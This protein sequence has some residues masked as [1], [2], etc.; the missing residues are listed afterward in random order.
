MGSQYPAGPPRTGRAVSRDVLKYRHASAGALILAI[1]MVFASACDTPSEQASPTTAPTSALPAPLFPN[2]PAV[3]NDFRFHWSAAPG[4][5]LNSGPAV[6]LR[7]YLES[8]RLAAFAGGDPSVVYPGFMRST[9]ENQ[10]PVANAGELFQLEYIRPQTRAEYEANGW[11]YVERQVYGYQPTHVLS[12]IPQGDGYRATVCVGAYSVYRTADDDPQKFFSTAA[13]EQTGQ[14]T[15]G[16]RDEIQVW[17][18]ELT[19]NDPRVANAPAPPT[20]QQLGPMPAPVDDVFG[21]WFI[22]GAG[23]ALWGPSGQ[24]EHIDTPE[25]RQQCEDAMPDDA[26]ART[27]MATGFHDG[28]PPHGEPVPGWPAETQ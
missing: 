5:D 19:E 26:A 11:T 3:A 15:Y 27:A 16:D 2:W 28:P 4:I 18:V 8:T 17:R 23:T 22:T 10:G 9:P 7:A 25:V 12:L 24:G 20:A 1:A 21:R 13:D 6:P 14:L